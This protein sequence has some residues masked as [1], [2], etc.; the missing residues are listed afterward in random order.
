MQVTAGLGSCWRLHL[1]LAAT[2]VLYMHVPREQNLRCPSVHLKEHSA[3]DMI[4]D[5]LA[6]PWPKR[7]QKILCWLS[8]TPCNLIFNLSKKGPLQKRVHQL[9]HTL[10]Q[11]PCAIYSSQLRQ[12]C[13][14]CYLLL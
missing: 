3:E 13:I 12:Q 14:E 6:C 2:Q 9:W 10:D 1:P 11:V 5:M 4:L 7:P 8:S